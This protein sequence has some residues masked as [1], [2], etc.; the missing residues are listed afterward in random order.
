MRS[1][2]SFPLRIAAA[3]AHIER[4]FP[5]AQIAAQ[6]EQACTEAAR[7]RKTFFLKRRGLARPRSR[8]LTLV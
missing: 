6:W 4:R 8:G 7:L 5:P 2:G 3:K 1:P